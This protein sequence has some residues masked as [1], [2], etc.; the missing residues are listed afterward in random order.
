MTI[1][2]QYVF[3]VQPGPRAAAQNSVSGSLTKPRPLRGAFPIAENS[4]KE[5][6]FLPMFPELA[7]SKSKISSVASVK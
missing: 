1:L 2:R 4:A 7:K 3:R 5:F 6:L